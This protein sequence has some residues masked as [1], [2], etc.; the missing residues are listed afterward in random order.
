MN[1]EKGLALVLLLALPAAPVSDSL[2]RYASA[3]AETVRSVT[4]AQSLSALNSALRRDG[5]EWMLAKGAAEANR[6]RLIAATFA[7]DVAGAGMDSEPGLVAPLIEWGCEQ[8]R[9]RMPSDAERVWHVAALALLEGTGS[10]QVVETHLAHASARFREDPAWERARLWLADSRTLDIHPRQPLPAPRI[11]FPVELAARYE[12]LAATPEFAGDAWLR[13]GFLHFLAGQYAEA[14]RDF[15][16][17]QLADTSNTRTRYLTQL[18]IGWIFE[19]EGKHTQAITAFR[20]AMA[21]EP[22]G[23]TAAAWLATRYAIAGRADE[24]EMVAARSLDGDTAG[25]DPWRTFYRGDLARWP[26]LIAASRAAIG[27]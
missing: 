8:I 24:A 21:A 6:R 1:R 10:L 17:G 27:K 15:T 5:T 18:F 19:R 9:R 26:A 12:S 22:A 7:L 14:R 11:T 20:A 23:R 3:P 25:P 13:I 16:T 4:A 2:D